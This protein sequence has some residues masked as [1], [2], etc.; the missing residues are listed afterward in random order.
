[1]HHLTLRQ[2]QTGLANKEF[3][4]VE[5]TQH[6][7]N[8]IQQLDSTLNS[9]ITLNSEQALEQAK[10]ADQQ[11]AAGSQAPL[12]GIPLAHKDN[13]CTQGLRT[14][15]GSKM[16]DNFIAPYNAKIIDAFNQNGS[17]LLGKTNMDEF[18][19]GSS[20]ESSF[21]GPS[22]NPW[23]TS[24]VP[25]GS[26]GGSAAAVAALLAPAATGSDTGGSVRQPAAFCNLTGFKPTYGLV[27]RYG[28]IA[29]AS[30]LDQAGTLSRTAEDAALLL[31]VMA[32]QDPRDS[33]SMPNPCEDY[34]ASLGQALNGVK[35]GFA[36]AFLQR[37]PAEIASLTEQAIKQFEQLGAEIIEIELPHHDYALA[38]Y[39]VI[40]SAEATSNLSRYDGVRYG[41]RCEQAKDL[42]DL[43]FRTRAEGFGTEVK[44]RILFGTHVLTADLYQ[45][46]FQQALKVR[47]LIQQD[48]LRAFEKVDIIAGPSCLDTAFALAQ[49]E[50]DQAAQSDYFTTPASLAGLPAISIPCGTSNGLPIGLQ[51]VGPAFADVKVLNLAHQFQL[52][53]DWHTKTAEFAQ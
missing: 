51:L 41:Y 49:S 19:M 15:A 10:Q 29:L 44:K 31:N 38:A 16:L 52:A 47:R 35:V 17:I 28:M 6:Y 22:K 24:R 45:S 2:L 25:G 30:S 33:N 42:M 7:L 20:N 27:S 13:F 5:L 21:Y 18:A 36:K 34:T 43:Y 37:L 23:D 11:L 9:F 8:R 26:S 3:S 48:Y 4:S 53:T 39:S 50:Q 32:G 40:S 1:M 12:C 46:H 14:S